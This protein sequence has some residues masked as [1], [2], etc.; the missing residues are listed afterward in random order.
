MTCNQ[1]LTFLLVFSMFLA[2]T[3]PFLATCLLP[4]LQ[5]KGLAVR[6][7]DTLGWPDVV[8]E[9]PFSYP[10]SAWTLPNQ[11]HPVTPTPPPT[12]FIP[13]PK[14]KQKYREECPKCRRKYLYDHVTWARGHDSGYTCHCPEDP[15]PTQA[16][17][18]QAPPTNQ[19]PSLHYKP[20]RICGTNPAHTW[21][22]CHEYKCPHCHIYA[23]EHLPHNCKQQPRK[24]RHLPQVKEESRLPTFNWEHEGYYEIKGYKDGNLNGENWLPDSYGPEPIFPSW[25]ELTQ[26]LLFKPLLP[27][28]SS[29]Q[30]LFFFTPPSFSTTMPLFSSPELIINSDKYYLPRGDLYILVQDTMFRVHQY[31]F[32]HDS[33]LFRTQLEHYKNDIFN[34]TQTGTTCSDAIMFFNNQ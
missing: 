13:K 30:T 7:T 33:T 12:P 5:A 22:F 28:F 10:L 34:P 31:F 9:P 19:C 6:I 4:S 32:M 26:F 11:N 21:E 16:T 2:N 17:F 20:C 24:P 25:L 23:P 27:S 3:S 18:S 29:K 14:K 15:S 8:G 1:H